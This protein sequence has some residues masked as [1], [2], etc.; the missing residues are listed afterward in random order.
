MAL[1]AR[2]CLPCGGYDPLRGGACLRL[3][4]M[5]CGPLSLHR[6]RGRAYPRRAGS[7]GGMLPC[8]G[9]SAE[10]LPRDSGGGGMRRRG[11]AAAVY[12]VRGSGGCSGRFIWCGALQTQS[13]TQ[14]STRGRFGQNRSIILIAGAD[15]WSLKLHLWN[16]AES[17][18]HPKKSINPKF[19]F[20]QVASFIP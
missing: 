15:L 1:G 19:Y 7:H 20:W 18:F 11:N 5:T 17:K 9:A 16:F 2:A 12:R 10:L 4:P 14:S 3:L 13:S 8:G 6:R